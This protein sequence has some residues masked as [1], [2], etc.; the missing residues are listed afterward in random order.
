MPNVATHDG[1][2]GV[3]EPLNEL[4]SFDDE[5]SEGTELASQPS[6]GESFPYAAH[7]A[8]GQGGDGKWG[9]GEGEGEGIGVHEALA[10][11]EAVPVRGEGGA[12][13]DD[14]LR[15]GSREAAQ[16]QLR[17]LLL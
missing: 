16:R 9:E 7:G 4:D 15:R 1:V 8:E 3:R 5:P 17:D 14:P 6:A 11:G 10:G 13:H 12:G 2:V